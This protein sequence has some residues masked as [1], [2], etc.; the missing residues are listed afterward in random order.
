M[1]QILIIED[2]VDLQRI[3]AEELTSQGYEVITA[4]MGTEGFEL[5]KYHKPDLILLDLMLPGHLSGFDFIN[6]FKNEP[7]L[8]S[9]HLIVLSNLDSEAD[10]V[11]AM[12]VTDFIV[13]SNTSLEVLGERIKKLFT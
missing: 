1:K 13:K 7:S 4:F 3:Y 10:K 8:V 11:R 5:A 12:G 2:D 9:T 6:K